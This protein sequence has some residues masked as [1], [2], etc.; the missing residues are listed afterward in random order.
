MNTDPDHIRNGLCAQVVRDGTEI[1]L[2]LRQIFKFDAVDIDME[3]ILEFNNE[4]L[5]SSV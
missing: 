5:C 1:P 4:S 2:T 3:A